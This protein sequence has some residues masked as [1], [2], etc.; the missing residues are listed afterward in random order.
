MEFQDSQIRKVALLAR[1][2]LSP[3]ETAAY[4]RD[5]SRIL[6]MVREIEAADT[7]DVPPLHHPLDLTLRLRE[8]RVTEQDRRE[9]YRRIAPR[10]RAGLYL[11]PQFI[12]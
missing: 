12:E 7:K 10:M 9:P 6:D 4:S 2:A 1:L 8:D 11:V 5:F 3:A